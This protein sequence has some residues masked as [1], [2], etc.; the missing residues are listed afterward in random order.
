MVENKIF[1]LEG[2]ENCGKSSTIKDVFFLLMKKYK[3][4]KIKS[5]TI[6]PNCNDITVQIV[7]NELLI[8]IETEGD[9][10]SCLESSLNDFDKAN[11]NIIFCPASTPYNITKELIY[12][13]RPKYE[14]ITRWQTIAKKRGE[15]KFKSNLAVAEELIRKAGL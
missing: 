7:I 15:Q 12:H 4:M 2:K 5:F 9:P 3:T 8:G 10:D 1:V 11:C 6:N 13:H 14:I